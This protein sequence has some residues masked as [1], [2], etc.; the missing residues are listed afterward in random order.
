MLNLLF[1]SACRG[2]P[3]AIKMVKASSSQPSEL[4]RELKQLRTEL[5]ILSRVRHPNIVRLFGGSLTPPAF[6][7]VEELMEVC[8]A[9]LNGTLPHPN[10]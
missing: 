7:L 4:A 5:T 2:Q 8:A 9:C 1:T 3:V 6:F 10:T